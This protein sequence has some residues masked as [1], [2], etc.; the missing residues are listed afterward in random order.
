LTSVTIHGDGSKTMIQIT[1]V[2][3]ASN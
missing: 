2:K 1:R 3:K